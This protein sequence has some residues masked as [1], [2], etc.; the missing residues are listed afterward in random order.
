MLM[1][2]PIS[3]FAILDSGSTGKSMTTHDE[4][5]LNLN[6]TSCQPMVTTC[7]QT[8]IGELQLSE[9]HSPSAGAELVLDDHKTGTLNFCPV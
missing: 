4:T 1:D 7:M 5:K 6:L 3:S 8:A 2:S 9:A